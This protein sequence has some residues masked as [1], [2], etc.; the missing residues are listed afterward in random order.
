MSKQKPDKGN[1]K[2]SRSKQKLSI[3]NKK[4]YPD[5]QN[6][7]LPG[8]KGVHIGHTLGLLLKK[9]GL[10]STDLCNLLGVSRQTAQRMLRKKYLHARLLVRISEV[11]Q[12]DVVRY[13]YLPEDLPGNAAL[14][15]QV[16]ELEKENERLKKENKMLEEMNVLLRREQKH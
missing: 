6:V 7:S 9:L 15:K 12:H 3:G 5:H 10:S 1:Q 16:E 8:C 4:V 2:I 14:K 11:L 13:L